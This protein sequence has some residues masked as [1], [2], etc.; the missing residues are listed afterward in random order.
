MIGS[1]FAGVSGLNANSVAM[2]VIGDNIANVN[3]TGFKSNRASFANILSQSLEGSMGSDVGRGVYLWT[4]NPAWSQGSLETTSNA[5]DLAINGRGFFMVR[6]ES[7]SVCFTRAGE[8]RFDKDGKLLNPDGLVVQ[9]YQIDDDGTLGNLGDIVIPLGS[10]RPQESSE[11]SLTVNLDSDTTGEAAASG[12]LDGQLTIQA[13]PGLA[14]NVSVELVGGGAVAE[15]STV[16]CQAQ[17]A[18]A[19][20]EYFTINAPGTGYYVWYD[21]DNGSVD[22]APAGL[23]GIEVDIATGDTADQV[24]AKTAAALDAAADFG[25][26]ANGSIVT[27][28]NVAAGDA[29]NAADNNTGFTIATATDGMDAVTAGNETVT[30]NGSIMTVRIE[31]GV[32][33]QQ[34]I[35]DALAGHGI[36]SSVTPAAAGAAW[37]LGV[38]T[39]STGLTGGAD[40]GTYATTITVYDSLGND[41]PL[42]MTFTKTSV[43]NEWNWAASVPSSVGS[44]AAGSGTIT[45]NSDGTLPNGAD[46]TISLN[47]TTGATTPLDFTWDLFADSGVS[48]GDLTGYA[49]SSTTTFMRQ[50][51]YASG[52]LQGVVV[53]ERGVI[54]GLYSNGRMDFYQIA[55][56]DFPSYWGLA[57]MG[58]N[59]YV[60]TMASGEAMPTPAGT[61]R[62]GSISPNALEMSNVDLAQEFV[63]MITT[64]RAFQANSKVITTSDQLLEDLINIKR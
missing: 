47:L 21:I 3:T 33:T 26:A 1:L 6:D 55:L 4:T 32:S 7:G 30:L 17:S 42:T 46:E 54:T 5:T 28:T 34:Q 20:G 53:D 22:P 9:G 57:K 43:P 64:Q 40:G 35:C 16:G 56:A 48:N 49:S 27:I 61:G 36:I 24:A 39:D 41:I 10:N 23:T 63:E 18:L 52:N 45:F 38:G 59:L 62:V 11:F 29:G 44:V 37:T 25:A 50:D 58:K 19:G 60:K 12:V 2:T 31:D 51:G 8:F 13:V 15:V 14:G